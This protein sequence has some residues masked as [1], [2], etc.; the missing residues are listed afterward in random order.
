[1]KK[2]SLVKIV[3]PQAFLDDWQI[4]NNIYVGWQILEDPTNLLPREECWEQCNLQLGK[5]YR[6]KKA[7]GVKGPRTGYVEIERENGLSAFVLKVDLE[8]VGD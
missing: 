8:E 4:E 5:E 6:I 7:R 2:G 3:K 1:M